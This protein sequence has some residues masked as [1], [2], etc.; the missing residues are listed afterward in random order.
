M[1]STLDIMKIQKTIRKA[2]KDYAITAKHDEE[3]LICFMSTDLYL[4]LTT[5]DA[6]PSSKRKP[7]PEVTPLG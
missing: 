2:I 5:E 3:V 1:S 4:N 6:P 7:K